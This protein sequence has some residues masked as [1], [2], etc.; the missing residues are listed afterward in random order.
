MSQRYSALAVIL[1]SLPELGPRLPQAVTHKNVRVANRAVI[2]PEAVAD[3]TGNLTRLERPLC[4]VVRHAYNDHRLWCGIAIPAKPVRVHPADCP[5]QPQR[6]A[7]QINR[8]QPGLNRPRGYLSWIAL[9]RV[10]N[11][12]C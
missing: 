3:M 2:D 12:G 5:R 10:E 6:R 1:E 8:G 9:R 7:V 11:R 4:E